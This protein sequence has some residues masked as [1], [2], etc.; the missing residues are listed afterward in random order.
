MKDDFTSSVTHELRTP[1]I[2]IRALSELMRDDDTMALAQRQ[3]FLDIIVTEAERLSRL[4]NQVLDMAKIEAG[5]ADWSS[6]AVNLR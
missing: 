3:Q 2:S 6:T 5:Q 1:L 4:V